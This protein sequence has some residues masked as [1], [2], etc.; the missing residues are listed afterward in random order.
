M[1]TNTPCEIILADG[2][3]HTFLSVRPIVLSLARSTMFG[4]TTAFSSN[5]S[6]HRLHPIYGGE[7]A[8]AI[9]FA[10]A[11]PSNAVAGRLGRVLAG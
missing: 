8:S 3:G 2:A 6:V 4:S 10:S 7:Q 1:Q 11:A 9:S 5:V